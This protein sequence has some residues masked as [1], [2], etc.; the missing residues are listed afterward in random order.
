MNKSNAKKG[1]N[2]SNKGNVASKGI[3]GN[4][5]DGGDNTCETPR[6]TTKN[7]VTRPNQSSPLID[8]SSDDEMKNH[9]Y[10]S[11][12]PKTPQPRTINKVNC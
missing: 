8:S 10:E 11:P 2:G 7:S 3:S 4:R 5:T 9:H 6:N 1:K 12:A